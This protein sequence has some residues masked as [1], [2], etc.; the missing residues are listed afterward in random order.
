ML[1]SALYHA[2]PAAVI[3]VVK[4]APPSAV[5]VMIVG[6]NPGLEDLVSQLS[7][8]HVGLSTATLVHLEVAVERWSDFDLSTG[9]R[10]VGSWTRGA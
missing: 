3:D 4:G 1:S 2:T 9:A 7:G 8:E 6:H 5:R 10:L